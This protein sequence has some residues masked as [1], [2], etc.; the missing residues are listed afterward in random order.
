MEALLEGANL[1]RDRALRNAI[2][3]RG[4]GEAARF[5][6]IAEYLERLDLH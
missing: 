6:E 5:G 3:D 4:P 1:L 2:R